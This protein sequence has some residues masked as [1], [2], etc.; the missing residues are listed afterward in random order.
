MANFILNQ[1]KATVARS[2]Q[3]GINRCDAW[4]GQQVANL[5]P[6]SLLDV[7]CGDGSLLFR[8]LNPYFPNKLHKLMLLTY[9][10]AA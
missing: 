10:E 6:D 4:A 8:H 2:R 1:L 9:T 5:N 7:G 3:A